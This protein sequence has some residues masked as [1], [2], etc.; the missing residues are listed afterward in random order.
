MLI[1]LRN[2]CQVL[3]QYVAAALRACRFIR[4]TA[5]EKGRLIQGPPLLL[6]VLALLVVLLPATRAQPRLVPMESRPGQGELDTAAIWGHQIGGAQAGV[7][8]ALRTLRCQ[9]GEAIVGMRIR[10]S[11]VLEFMQVLCAAP[12]CAAANCQWTAPPRPEASEGNP[13]GGMLQPEM[14]CDQHEMVASIK[15]RVHTVS[16]PGVG[17]AFDYAADIEIECSRI[18]LVSPNNMFGVIAQ[19]GNWH[20]PQGSLTTAPGGQLTGIITCRPNGGVTAISLGTARDIERLQQHVRVIQAVSLYCPA[21]PQILD[22]NCPD[23]LNLQS[24]ADRFSVV[25]ATWFRNGGRTGGAIA[26]VMRAVPQTRNWQGTQV[27]ETVTL[28]S[29]CPAIPN[30]APIC[31]TGG[32]RVFTLEQP[33]HAQDISLRPAV[34]L[35]VPSVDGPP[36]SFVDVHG[37]FDNGPGGNPVGQNLLAQNPGAATCTITCS[38]TYTCG[39]RTY[40]PFTISYS[41]V[42]AQFAPAIPVSAAIPV[43]RVNVTK[44]TAR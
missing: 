4:C 34:N 24:V 21:T 29:G 8:Y 32:H 35:S 26:A 17:Y 6:T 42:R 23:D 43:T 22:P 12:R 36:N 14:Q 25:Q 15:G 11:N 40:G 38:Q 19:A 9:T 33:S 27:T 13:N 1:F 5:P 39:N 10:R 28:A 30:A 2:A 31:G 44:A 41:F 37:S 18:T 16:R 3:H 7:D 20:A